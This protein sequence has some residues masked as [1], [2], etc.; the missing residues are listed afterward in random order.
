MCYGTESL[1]FLQVLKDCQ[2]GRLLFSIQAI[3]EM[4][5]TIKR[6]ISKLVSVAETYDAR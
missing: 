1:F 2:L 4:V 5:T 3:R 6:K